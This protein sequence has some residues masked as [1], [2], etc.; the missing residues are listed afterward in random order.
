MPGEVADP[1]HRVC[2]S[3]HPCSCL[4]KGKFTHS[5]LCHTERCR[6]EGAGPSGDCRVPASPCSRGGK[7]LQGQATSPT[8]PHDARASRRRGL[9]WAEQPPWAGQSSVSSEATD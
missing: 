4:F 7:T 9:F 1:T 5:S 2:K 8:H 3:Q 6:E